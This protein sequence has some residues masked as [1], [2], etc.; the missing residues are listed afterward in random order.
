MA[1]SSSTVEISSKATTIE[2]GGKKLLVKLVGEPLWD[3][4]APSDWD[5]E[6]HSKDAVVR[7]KR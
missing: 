5:K 2:A 3:P 1:S 7:I 4:F 6:K